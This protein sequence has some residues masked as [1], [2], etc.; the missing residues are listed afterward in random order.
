MDKKD[1]VISKLQILRTW[2]AVNPIHGMGLGI[3]DCENA[4]EWLDA[5]LEL[6]KAQ[7]PIEPSWRRGRPFCGKCGEI[8]LIHNK[9]C[10]ECGRMVKWE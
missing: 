4:V 9:Y 6:L 7:E 10:S 1:K 8:L 2:C 3:D 5:A